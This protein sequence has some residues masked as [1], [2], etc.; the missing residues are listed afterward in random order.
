MACIL[1]YMGLFFSGLRVQ[2]SVCGLGV[3]GCPW[4]EVRSEVC[5]TEVRGPGVM[6]GQSAEMLQA[7][8]RRR[9]CS[10]SQCTKSWS[11]NS[12]LAPYRL[13]TALPDRPSCRPW[14][15]T[16]RSCSSPCCCRPCAGGGGGSALAGALHSLAPRE[17]AIRAAAAHPLAAVRASSE[18]PPKKTTFLWDEVSGQ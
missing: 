17:A 8:W 5:C 2:R 12:T 4:N 13:R 16:A 15:G 14:R 11:K 9:S 1:S 18:H 10:A 3:F 6:E 7:R